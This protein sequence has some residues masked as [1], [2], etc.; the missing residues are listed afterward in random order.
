MV[1]RVIDNTPRRSFMEKLI[2]SLTCIDGFDRHECRL[3]P[4]IELP[5]LQEI[6]LRDEI[7]HKE[8][9]AVDKTKVA[10]GVNL[11]FTTVCNFRQKY[12]VHDDHLWS[13]VWDLG[14]Y[15]RERYAVADHTSVKI[16]VE[17]YYSGLKK[18]LE[19]YL[20]SP[21]H[22]DPDLSLE[23]PTMCALMAV[24]RWAKMVE[25][26]HDDTIGL[27][28]QAQA[29]PRD[30]SKAYDWENADELS[31]FDLRLQRDIARRERDSAR[32]ERDE[33]KANLNNLCLQLRWM[34][35]DS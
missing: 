21:V 7:I 9:S 14:P 19:P 30:L 13:M 35:S 27:K 5:G 29:P 2:E 3:P 31:N 16:A 28:P 12:G 4:G 10:K 25:G 17:F 1:L 20:R 15:D 34:T 24:L 18:R 6:I 32:V 23:P 33:A 11:L 8:S 26:S 22:L